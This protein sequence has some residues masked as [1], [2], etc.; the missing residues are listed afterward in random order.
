MFSILMANY[1]AGGFL[2]AS[3]KSVLNQTDQNW[4]LVIVDDASPESVEQVVQPFLTDKR[5]SFIRHKSNSGYGKT[6]RTAIEHSSGSI[7]GILDSDDAL[8]SNAIRVMRKAHKKYPEHQLIYSQYMQCDQAL[9]PIKKGT[10]AQI[11]EGV[12]W[13][14]VIEKWKQPIPRVSHFKTFTRAA[15]NKTDGFTSYRRTVD[16]DIVLKL[17]EV[18]KL[19]FV[20]KVLYYY[21]LHSKALTRDPRYPSRNKE[22]IALTKKRRAHEGLLS[23]DPV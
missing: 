16:K 19:K 1:D 18:T 21:R 15:Y 10:C 8:D 14:E 6:L 11:P 3:I 9:K 20:D 5:I 13:L 17:E 4:E 7:C 23:S 12:S 2:P 22:V